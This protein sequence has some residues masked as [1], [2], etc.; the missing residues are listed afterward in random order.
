V[1]TFAPGAQTVKA[2]IDGY[3]IGKNRVV[4]RAIRR[5]WRSNVMRS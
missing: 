2:D 5:R 3:E 4:G 1:D